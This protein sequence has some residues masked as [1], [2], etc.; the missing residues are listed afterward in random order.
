MLTAK[1][2]DAKK[3]FSISDNA[4]FLDIWFDIMDGEEVLDTRRL[5]FPIG[6]SEEEIK[7]AVRKY[8]AMYE[9][10]YSLAKTVEERA[11]AEREAESVLSNLKG[12][13]IN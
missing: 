5:A 3:E 1:I 13:D 10:D 11:E 7:E 4:T 6:T 2:T 9:N 8:Y 12:Q